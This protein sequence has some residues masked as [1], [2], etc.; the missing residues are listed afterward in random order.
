MAQRA[1]LDAAGN[2]HER[3][4]DVR[5]GVVSL[6]LRAYYESDFGDGDIEQL[7]LHWPFLRVAD[8]RVLDPVQLESECIVLDGCQRHSQL[9]HHHAVEPLFARAQ[10]G[11]ECIVLDGR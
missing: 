8:G 1:E 3:S 10:L 7:S 2:S 11:W 9:V 4:V 6:W 5:S